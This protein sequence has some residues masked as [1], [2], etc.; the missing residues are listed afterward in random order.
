MSGSS[1]HLRA[2]AASSQATCKL[3]P[4]SRD[5]CF[6]DPATKRGLVLAN[7]KLDGMVGRP[8]PDRRVRPAP[9]Q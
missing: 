9:C 4:A 3:Q 1:S 6:R 8:A 5:L 2:V 7:W